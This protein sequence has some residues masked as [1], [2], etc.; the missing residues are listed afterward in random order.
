[1]A[2]LN[3]SLF[4]WWFVVLSTCRTVSL[5]EIGHFRIGLD[6]ME[7]ALKQ[8]LSSFSTELMSDLKRHA[9]RKETFYKATGRVVFDEFSPRNSKYIMD[10]LDRVLAQHDGFTDEELDFIINYDIK[11]RMGLGNE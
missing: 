11:Y 10:K 3:R 1:M 5:R 4:Y 2:T 8:R 7:L 9:K 6:R